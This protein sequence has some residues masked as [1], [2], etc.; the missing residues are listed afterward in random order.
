M[1]GLNKTKTIHTSDGYL[2]TWSQVPD[3]PRTNQAEDL[4]R[5][6]IAVMDPGDKD[7]PNAASLLAAT[8]NGNGLT[9]AGRTQASQIVDRIWAQWRREALRFQQIEAR[10]AAAKQPS[11]EELEPEGRA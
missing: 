7:L 9:I 2:L 6:A 4:L 3:H 8:I 11:L 10:G 5:W 1:T